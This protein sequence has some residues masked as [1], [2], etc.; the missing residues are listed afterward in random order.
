MC[1]KRDTEFFE[2]LHDTCPPERIPAGTRPDAGRKEAT[3]KIM[4]SKEYSKVSRDSD[5]KTVQKQNDEN[6]RKDQLGPG[7]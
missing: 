1:N 7:C 2:F 4:E 5:G 3:A 6:S